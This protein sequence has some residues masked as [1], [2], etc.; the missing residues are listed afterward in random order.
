MSG[1]LLSTM[2]LPVLMQVLEKNDQLYRKEF[3]PEDTF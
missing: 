3:G 1:V 2:I